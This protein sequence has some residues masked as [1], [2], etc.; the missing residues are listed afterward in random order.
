MAKFDDATFTAFRLPSLR[1]RPPGRR[2]SPS[3]NGCVGVK[4]RRAGRPAAGA[5]GGG[6]GGGGGGGR[7]RRPYCC[8]KLVISTR[9]TCGRTPQWRSSSA[10]PPLRQAQDRR[11]PSQVRRMSF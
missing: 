9:R 10:F 6:G 8:G 3:R 4:R 7:G 11:I 5:A 1:R 2:L